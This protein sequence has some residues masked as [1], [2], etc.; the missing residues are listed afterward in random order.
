MHSPELY[1]IVSLAQL[2]LSIQISLSNKQ[3][4][5]LRPAVLGHLPAPQH[6]QLPNARLDYHLPPQQSVHT[7]SFDIF[8]VRHGPGQALLEFL[9]MYHIISLTL[10][11][12]NYH[13]PG[14]Y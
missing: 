10:S 9:I 4:I 5:Q 8:P 7:K 1:Q 2:H 14:P 11:Y 6:G 12:R 13:Y 3:E